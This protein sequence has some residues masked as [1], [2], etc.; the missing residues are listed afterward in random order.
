MQEDKFVRWL[1]NILSCKKHRKRILFGTPITKKG[2]ERISGAP[3][4]DK[5]FNEFFKELV[6]EGVIVLVQDKKYLIEPEN[7]WKKI[8]SIGFGKRFDNLSREKHIWGSFK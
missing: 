1:V 5:A 8:M 3:E 6:S 7:A 4:N 2:F